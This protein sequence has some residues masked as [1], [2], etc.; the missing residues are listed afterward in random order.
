MMQFLKKRVKINKNKGVSKNNKEK[1]VIKIL[2]AIIEMKN[3]KENFNII[4]NTPE[5]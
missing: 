1:I 2:N 3:S 5:E 4:L